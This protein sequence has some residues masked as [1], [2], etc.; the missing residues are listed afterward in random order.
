MTV[1]IIVN[2]KKHYTV[3]TVRIWVCI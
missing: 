2:D 1:I 3:W